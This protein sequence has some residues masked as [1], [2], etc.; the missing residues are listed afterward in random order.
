MRSKFND[1]EKQ[2]RLF[3]P[4]NDSVEPDDLSSDEEFEEQEFHDADEDDEFIHSTDSDSYEESAAD[5]TVEGCLGDRI[6]ELWSARETGLTHDYAIA[7]WLLSI[8]P[9]VFEDAKMHNEGHKLSLDR[10]CR[11]LFNAATISS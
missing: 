7:R 1:S 6:F 5:V 3:C 10:V 2:F 4:S 8:T 9:E 11:R